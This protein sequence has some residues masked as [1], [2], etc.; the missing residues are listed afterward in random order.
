MKREGGLWGNIM[1]HMPTRINNNPRYRTTTLIST[2]MN[3]HYAT[4]HK[5]SNN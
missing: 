2:G 4:Q 1:H 3:I 5:I